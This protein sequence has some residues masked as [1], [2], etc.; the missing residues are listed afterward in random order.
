MARPSN[1][2]LDA[3]CRRQPP[4]AFRHRKDCIRGWRRSYDPWPTTVPSS[5][6]FH[7]RFQGGHSDWTQGD[8]CWC[9][10]VTTRCHSLVVCIDVCH[11]S[12]CTTYLD[13]R[14]RRSAATARIGITTPT[15]SNGPIPSPM[16]KAT[17]IYG[18]L[19]WHI[20][21]ARVL[22]VS[23][24]EKLVRLSED[25]IGFGSRVNSRRGSFVFEFRPCEVKALML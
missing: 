19:C 4:I 17:D 8:C 6:G 3:A 20:G 15:S 18:V 24:L 7:P 23:W 12:G 11:F 16:S 9:F 5:L 10:G 22:T 25:K 13:L 21:P 2:V 14:T 1:G